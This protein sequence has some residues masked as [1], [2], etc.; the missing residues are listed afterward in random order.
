MDCD[1]TTSIRSLPDAEEFWLADSGLSEGAATEL[2]AAKP[3][4]GGGVALEIFTTRYA[5]GPEWEVFC[6]ERNP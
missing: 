3:S 6:V 1:I 4:T 5:G 2:L